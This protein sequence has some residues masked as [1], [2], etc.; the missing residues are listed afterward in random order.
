MLLFTQQGRTLLLAAVLAVWAQTVWAQNL[1]KLAVY[2]SGAETSAINNA[3]ATGLIIALA[4]RPGRYQVAKNYQEIF[5]YALKEQKS[6]AA[7]MN[8]EQIKKLGN[9]FGVRYIC[10]AE[11]IPIFGEN[12]ISARI[13]DVETGKSEAIGTVDSPLKSQTD[14]VNVSEQI[15]AK[16]FNNAPA[17]V[18]APTPIPASTPA[19]VYA[20]TSM[21]PAVTNAPPGTNAAPVRTR[22]QYWTG[23]GGKGIRLIVLE[24]TG[25]G[26]AA[27]EQWMLSLVQGTITADFNKYSAMDVIDRMNVEKVMAE[28]KESMSGNYSE[29][30]LV[31]I[32]NLTSAS[33]ILS[34]SISKTASA[35]ML[36]LSVTDVASGLR[37]A[38]YSPTPIS[39]MAL[40]NLSAIKAASADLLRQLGVE[41]TGA[42]Q[43]ELKQVANMAQI[44]AQTMLSHGI[45]A[46][47]QGT[48][49]AALSYFFQAAAFDSSLI[50]A[51][52]RSSVM[53]ANISSGNI[54]ADARNAI[55]WRKNW[56]ARLTE[57]EVTFQ[58]LINAATPY[59]LFYATDIKTG[60]INYKKEAIDLS[61]SINLSADVSW[62]NAMNRAL[63]AAD[64]VLN[65]LNATKM[66]GDWGLSYWPRNGVSNTNPFAS[67]QSYDITVVFE[68][69]NEQGRVIGSQIVRL[70]PRFGIGNIKGSGFVIRF[71]ENALDTVNFNGVRADDISN[72]LTI[73]VASVNGEP[74]QNTRFAVRAVSAQKWQQNIFLRI[75]NGVVLGF[76][77]SHPPLLYLV[78]PDKAWG[79]PVTAIGDGAFANSGLT[80]ITIP[81]S[82]TSIGSRAFANNS[83]GSVTIPNSVTFIGDNAFAYSQLTKLTILNSR[84]TSI[85]NGAFSGCNFA[86]KIPGS[87]TILD[88][89]DDQRYRTVKIGN[90]TWMAK[91]LNYKTGNSRCY[92]DQ[93]S[94]CDKYGRLYD[95]YTAVTVC[96]P[97]WH[98]PSG[99]E[100]N[101]LVYAV[102]G[103]KTAGKKLKSTHGWERKNKK[104]SGDGTDDYGF[105]AL[106]GGR[107]GGGEPNRYY[108]AGRYGYWWMTN[109][110]DNFSAYNLL[111]IHYNNENVSWDQGE[112]DGRSVRCVED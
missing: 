2:A 5:E 81:N 100:W 36:E 112:L 38:S 77:G 15:V 63:K 43:R 16:M 66:K 24:P 85:G 18:Y 103:K 31:K 87:D 57:T 44:Q 9:R 104:K 3:T 78:I 93:E 91:N 54:G 60:S 45:A 82:V 80:G 53:A 47:R 29:V 97:G 19:P 108:N 32:G 10:V 21:L 35:F 61:I 48:E 64:A 69:V 52:K 23:N 58:T 83:I 72:N 68:L 76:N 71:T 39:A 101:G 98:L 28:W 26:L 109:S 30:N 41:L 49:V 95:W 89:R 70:N 6:G 33:H 17:P 55:V 59:T 42:G 14:I 8:T 96:A 99:Q 90:K 34:G 106:P 27:D 74:P 40:E 105:S 7:P 88:T 46:Q 84:Y 13:A 92:D 12:Q 65:G 94:N 11:I 22:Q 102:G 73:R 1:P 86:I 25:K 37:K 107:H 56:V 62:F 111:S 79:N 51:S 20:P 4:N 75:E 50:E 110:K 67:L